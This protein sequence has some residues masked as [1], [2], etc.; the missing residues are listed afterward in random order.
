MAKI[1][2]QIEKEQEWSDCK[3][4]IWALCFS[5][6]CGRHLKPKLDRGY[7]PTSLFPI[8]KMYSIYTGQP[9]KNS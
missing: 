2:E 7:M 9:S 5:P 6:E 4:N 3:Q 1:K 8:E